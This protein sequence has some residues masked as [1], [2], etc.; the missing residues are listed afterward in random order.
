MKPLSHLISRRFALAAVP[1]LTALA[2]GLQVTPTVWA[3]T[4]TAANLAMVGEPPTLDPMGS[5][6]DIVGT[7]MQHVYETLYTFDADWHIKPMLASDMPKVSADGLTVTIPLRAKVK[8]H[9]GQD[10]DSADVVA[11]LKRWMEL[12]SRGKSVAKETVS[13]EASGANAIVWKFKTPYGPL[14]SQLA[15]PSGM[16]AIMDKD[17]LAPTLTAFV[18][19]GPYQFKDRKPDQFILLS[20]FPSYSARTEAASGYAG[21]R[22]A[23]IDELRFIPVPNANTRV[24]GAL[25]GQF[26]YADALPAESISRLEKAGA[27]TVVPV[28]AQSSGF[29]Y[30]AFNTQEGVMSDKRLRQAVQMAMG[31]GELLAAALGDNRFFKVEANHFPQGSPFYSV[32]GKELYN[33]GDAKAAKAL[34]DKAGYN[35]Q[36]IRILNSRQY[37]FHHNLALMLAEQ[38]R[39]AGFKVELDVVDWA[40]LVQRRGDPKLMDM[41]ITHSPVLPEP[42]LSPPQLGDG[43]PGRWDTPAKQEVLKA[44]NAEMNPAQR[45]KLWGKVQAV[46]YDEVP[47]IQVGKFSSLAARSPKMQNFYPM[48]W[49]A[50]WNAKV[51]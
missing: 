43:A 36:P 15:M 12:A 16:A 24:E 10:M 47:Y 28:V 14:L 3:A 1:A 33:R 8:F 50:F 29:P 34:A 27:A 37:E 19:T 30:I 39:Q 45:G 7:I 32:A 35:G 22:D 21:K 51:N 44:F 5:T 9:N 4:T 11:S 40:T 6:A 2:L 13:L 18:G 25:S 31:D 38:L 42:M 46:V 17:S 23:V 49:P 48:T 20:K 41:Y 26:Q